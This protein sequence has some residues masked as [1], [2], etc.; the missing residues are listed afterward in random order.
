MIAK[1]GA[2]NARKLRPR[3]VPNAHRGLLVCAQ[4]GECRAGKLRIM[5]RHFAHQ[6]EKQWKRS[7]SAF[8]LRCTMLR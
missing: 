2:A 1:R 7:R 3:L 8:V 4:S 5:F 6:F